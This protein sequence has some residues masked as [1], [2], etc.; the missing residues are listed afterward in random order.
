MQ[1]CVWCGASFI[2]HLIPYY[3]IRNGE[4][5]LTYDFYLMQKKIEYFNHTLCSY[6]V[7]NGRKRTKSVASAINRHVKFISNIPSTYCSKIFPIFVLDERLNFS[8]FYTLHCFLL[9]RF[10]FLKGCDPRLKF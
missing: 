8:K 9:Y 1:K 2:L 6:G 10:R 4:S 3:N 5:L 7:L